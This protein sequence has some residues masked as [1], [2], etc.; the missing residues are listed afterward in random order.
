MFQ[1]WRD[2]NSKNN[3]HFNILDHILKI[4]NMYTLPGFYPSTFVY[5]RFPQKIQFLYCLLSLV[6]PWGG[7]MV[8]TEGKIFEIHV[9][10][11][12][13]NPFFLEFHGEF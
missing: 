3:L 7:S 1:F 8:D 10:R 9:C 11:L 5:S 2:G 12:L 6:A 4:P 13:E